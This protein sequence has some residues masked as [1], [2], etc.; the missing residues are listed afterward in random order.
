M[1]GSARG[2]DARQEHRYGLTPTYHLAAR[3]AIQSAQLAKIGV[4][5]RAGRH[6]DPRVHR[7]HP[8]KPAAAAAA[9]PIRRSATNSTRRLA[10]VVAR[11]L[12]A[13]RVRLIT[14]SSQQG[15]VA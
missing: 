8:G 14:A 10:R 6:L 9:S 15:D 4:L 12:Q 7:E 5:R 11:R 3:A 13:A 1:A 2:A